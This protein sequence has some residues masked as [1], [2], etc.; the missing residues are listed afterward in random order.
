MLTVHITETAFTYATPAKVTE[1]VIALNASAISLR[2]NNAKMNVH[3]TK[4]AFT[5]ATPAKVTDSVLAVP[6]VASAVAT[7]KGLRHLS[8]SATAGRDKNQQHA[9]G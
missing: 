2:Q 9:E 4:T 5:Y 6:V 7:Q 3:I 8:A 1:E